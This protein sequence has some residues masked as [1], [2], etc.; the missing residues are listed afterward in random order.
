MYKYIALLI[1]SGAVAQHVPIVANEG[2]LTISSQTEVSLLFKLENKKDAAVSNDGSVYYYSD[3]H[4][5]GLYTFNHKKKTSYAVFQPYQ[6]MVKSHKITGT[7][8]SYFFDVLFNNESLVDGFYLKNDMSIAGTANFT[9]GIVQVD[10]LS[11]ALVFEKQAKHI[12]TSDKSHVNGE[13]EKME[14]HKDAFK[15]PIG[16]GIYFRPAYISAPNDIKDAFLSQ[17]HLENPI[18]SHP[19]QH[20]ETELIAVINDKEYWTVERAADGVNNII[21]TLS[22]NEQT[23]PKSILTE[24]NGVLDLHIVRWDKSQKKWIDEGGIVNKELKTVTTPT[25]VR[26]YGVF[27]LARIKTMVKNHIEIYNAVATNSDKGNDFFRIEH[28]NNFPNNSVEIYNRWGV[29]VYGTQNYNSNGNVFRGISEG[30]GTFNKSDKLPSGTY[31]YIVNY[32]Y[33]DGTGPR[34]IKKAGY[35]HLEN[36]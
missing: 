7:A 25:I 28:I 27:T 21:L 6:G 30:R 22:W 29:K 32:E 26:D 10:S 14:Q 20:S 18:V 5:D 1:G 11:G 8:P 23:T 34:M 2:I 31:Y 33:D 15:F 16:N 24:E 35:L 3:F 19:Y 17:Y 9:A 13:V 4:N 12:N 36:N